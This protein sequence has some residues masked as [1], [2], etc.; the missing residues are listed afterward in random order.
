MRLIPDWRRVLLRSAAVWFSAASNV[1]FVLAGALYVFAD[2]L[3]DR[4]YFELVA[5][6]CVLG[7]LCVAVV[8]L[9]RIIKQDGLNAPPDA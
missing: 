1:F 9:A 2:E 4:A 7:F 8:P 5:V 3:G 6:L